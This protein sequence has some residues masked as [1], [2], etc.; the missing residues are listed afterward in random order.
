MWLSRLLTGNTPNLC[1]VQRS[2]L[3]RKVMYTLIICYGLI[4]VIF[5]GYAKICKGKAK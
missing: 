3:P 5:R 2:Q 1:G 4:T